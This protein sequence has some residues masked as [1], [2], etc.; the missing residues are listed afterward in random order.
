ML[1]DSFEFFDSA[2]VGVGGAG[3]AVVDSVGGVDGALEGVGIGTLFGEL[4]VEVADRALQAVDSAAVVV[5][6]ALQSTDV[7]PQVVS[8][9]LGARDVSVV[10]ATGLKTKA[11]V[12]IVRDRKEKSCY[13][14]CK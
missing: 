10:S 12:K 4:V 14:F 2:F 8:V 7:V 13:R 3:V 1:V 6:V 5:S 9:A 11:R